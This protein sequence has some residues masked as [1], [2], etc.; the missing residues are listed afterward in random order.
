MPASQRSVSCPFTRLNYSLGH[1]I[2]TCAPQSA[3][4]LQIIHSFNPTIHSLQFDSRLPCELDLT[5]Q[6][7]DDRSMQAIRSSHTLELLNE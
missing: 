1:T 7:D 5:Q 2:D 4:Y 3:I 6:K